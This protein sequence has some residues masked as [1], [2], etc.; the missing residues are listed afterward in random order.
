LAKSL[1]QKGEKMDQVERKNKVLYVYDYSNPHS[2]KPLACLVK[3]FEGKC[4]IS[5][6]SPKDSFNK[7]LARKIA[8]ARLNKNIGWMKFLLTEHKGLI[9]RTLIDISGKKTNLIEAVIE[10]INQ[11]SVNLNK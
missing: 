8:E 7:K 4:G 9:R 2:R 3:T 10:T 5:V 1:K 6:C 11:N